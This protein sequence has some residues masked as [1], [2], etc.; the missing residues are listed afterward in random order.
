MGLQQL[1]CIVSHDLLTLYNEI[2]EASYFHVGHG[3]VKH[4][5]LGVDIVTLLHSVQRTIV[6][7]DQLQGWVEWADIVRSSQPSV[8]LMGCQTVAT[9]RIAGCHNKHVFWYGLSIQCPIHNEFF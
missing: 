6:P 8:L 9:V 2:S 5:H 1:F 4:L 7:R 3:L